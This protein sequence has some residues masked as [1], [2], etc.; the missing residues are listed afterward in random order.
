M[1]PQREE[2]M[3]TESEGKKDSPVKERHCSFLWQSQFVKSKSG[4]FEESTVVPVTE[5]F[6][7][8]HLLGPESEKA[9]SLVTSIIKFPISFTASFP[10]MDIVSRERQESQA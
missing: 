5:R 10:F 9:P 2:A 6:R 7:G 3:G 4:I 8:K 1:Y